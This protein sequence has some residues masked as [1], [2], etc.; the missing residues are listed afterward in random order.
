[1]SELLA[2]RNSASWF[3]QRFI[4]K[5]PFFICDG[6]TDVDYIE[7]QMKN[8]IV[9]LRSELC[10]LDLLFQNIPTITAEKRT[11]KLHSKKSHLGCRLKL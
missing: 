10:G 2:S 4:Y 7:A 5:L 6:G 8:K 9:E 3:Q 1:V 11:I